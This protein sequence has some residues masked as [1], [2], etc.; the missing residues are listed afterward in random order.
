[1]LLC[2]LFRTARRQEGG[3]WLNAGQAVRWR[4]ELAIASAAPVTMS[5]TGGSQEGNVYTLRFTWRAR[6]ALP[7][8][9]QKSKVTRSTFDLPLQP[10]SRPVLTTIDGPYELK[11]MD[12]VSHGDNTPNTPQQPQ[13]TATTTHLLLDREKVLLG[14]DSGLRAELSEVRPRLRLD[15]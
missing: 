5:V 12:D 4:A 8:P 9:K 1:M 14:V 13:E 11:E 3:G 2:D 7:A 6:S 15:P 10:S